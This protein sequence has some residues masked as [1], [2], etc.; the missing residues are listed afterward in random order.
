MSTM[1]S[2]RKLLL[3]LVPVG[4]LLI[5]ALL[6][7]GHDGESVAGPA[8]TRVLGEGRQNGLPIGLVPD[9]AT[10]GSGR[11]EQVPVGETGLE[12]GEPPPVVQGSVSGRVVDGAGHPIAG[13]P[14]YL[15]LERDDWAPHANP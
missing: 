9:A 14:V 13:E 2:T 3:I 1:M 8:T 10:A 6:R 4:A 11:V 5:F 12:A 7:G 15:T